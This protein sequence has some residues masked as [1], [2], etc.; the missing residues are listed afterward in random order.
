MSPSS[1]AP[2]P[3]G[4]WMEL[5]LPRDRAK[6]PQMMEAGP[7]RIPGRQKNTTPTSPSTMLTT[8]NTGEGT[9]SPDAMGAGAGAEAEDFEGRGI[10]EVSIFG[11]V[12]GRGACLLGGSSEGGRSRSGIGSGLGDAGL[13][14]GLAGKGIFD[15]QMGH[16]TEV[17]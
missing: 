15:V 17:P 5:C 9:S 1:A 7:K 3:G 12:G 8:P 2:W 11:E 13:A 4:G 6:W 14:A 10:E 16:S